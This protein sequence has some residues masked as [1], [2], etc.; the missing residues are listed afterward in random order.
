MNSQNKN[1]NISNA[2]IGTL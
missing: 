1:R 2:M